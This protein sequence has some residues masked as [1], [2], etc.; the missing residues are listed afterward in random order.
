MEAGGDGALGSISLEFKENGVM[1]SLSGPQ[2][3]DSIACPLVAWPILLLGLSKDFR[4]LDFVVATCFFLSSKLRALPFLHHSLILDFL[5]G[6]LR[7]GKSEHSSWEDIFV[8]SHQRKV[9]F[10]ET[11]NWIWT[12]MHFVRICSQKGKNSRNHSLWS[13]LVRSDGE[14][15]RNLYFFGWQRTLLWVSTSFLMWALCDF[16][17]PHSV[18]L[19]K[20][21]MDFYTVWLN[22]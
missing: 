13:H 14:L 6:I 20:G 3:P 8:I 7:L 17:I 18:H 1:N 22:E 5:R 21:E 10:G 15:T 4:N 11:A 2:T 16:S 9:S 12:S 19:F